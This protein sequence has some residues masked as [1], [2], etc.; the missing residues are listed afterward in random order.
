VQDKLTGDPIVL[1]SIFL[2]ITILMGI[3]RHVEALLPVLETSTTQFD[4]A[5]FVVVPLRLFRWLLQKGI[6]ILAQAFAVMVVKIVTSAGPEYDTMFIVRFCFVLGI[7]SLFW[8]L[9][10]ALGIKM[11]E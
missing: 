3:K 2:Y 7:L 4:A 9:A 6:A 10:Y 1:I 5:E 8:T 11:F